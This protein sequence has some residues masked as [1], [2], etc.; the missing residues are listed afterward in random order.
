MKY[1]YKRAN[2]PKGIIL[3]TVNRMPKMITIDALL[4]VW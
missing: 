1:V 3:A 2:L 4:S